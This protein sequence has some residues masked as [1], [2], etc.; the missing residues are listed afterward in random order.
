MTHESYFIG[1]DGSLMIV[2]VAV[3]NLLHPGR[4]LSH[5]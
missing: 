1:F 3:F 4:L 2:A 5:I